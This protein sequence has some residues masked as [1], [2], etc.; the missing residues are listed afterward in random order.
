MFSTS[1]TAG[2]LS[3]SFTK[4]EQNRYLSSVCFS[5]VNND[6]SNAL[7][8]WLPGWLA[9]GLAGWL[10]VRLTGWLACWRAGWLVVW[11]AGWLGGWLA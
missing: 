7:A 10:L 4:T 11:L 8:G 1:T 9:A 5:M 3:T 2:C 6:V